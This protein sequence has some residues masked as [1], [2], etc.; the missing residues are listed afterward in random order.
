MGTKTKTTTPP[1]RPKLRLET[2]A[3]LRP[4]RVYEDYDYDSSVSTITPIVKSTSDDDDDV[5]DFANFNIDDT[6]D[7]DEDDGE[8]VF[9]EH[10]STYTQTEEPPKDVKEAID[11]KLSSKQLDDAINTAKNNMDDMMASFD[12]SQLSL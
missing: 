9:T 8:W 5:Y 6:E 3:S 1:N 4:T 12:F 10:Y 7:E 11:G 2:F